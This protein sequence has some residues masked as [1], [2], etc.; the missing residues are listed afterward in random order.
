MMKSGSETIF[1]GGKATF[2]DGSVI[3][4]VP[5]PFQILINP[6]LRTPFIPRHSPEFRR[7]HYLQVFARLKP[8]VMFAQARAAMAP[9][10]ENIARI[11]P[12]TNKGWG[13][14]IEPLRQALVGQDLQTTFWMLADVAG[15]VLLMACANIA[16]LLLVRGVSRTREIAVRALGSRAA[17]ASKVRRVSRPS[18][19]S[20]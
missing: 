16:N 7:M 15:F 2:L 13:I 11:A 18:R 20:L 12:D 5:A 8:G 19:S 3:G 14:T 17:T 6:I 10:A 9:I 1:V 4:I